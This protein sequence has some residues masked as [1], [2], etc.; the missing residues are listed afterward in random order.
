MFYLCSWFFK[1]PKS[2]INDVKR[3]NYIFSRNGTYYFRKRF[4]RENRQNDT[5]V[6]KLPSEIKFSLRTKDSA[7]AIIA[8]N[9]FSELLLRFEKQ[10]KSDTNDEAVIFFN[11]LTSFNWIKQ[12]H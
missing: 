2:R 8:A 3:N 7:Q 1:N 5:N 12:L 11:T 9:V 10:F 6:K 4:S